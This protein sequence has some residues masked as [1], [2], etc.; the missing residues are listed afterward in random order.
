MMVSPTYFFEQRRYGFCVKKQS[1]PPQMSG[2]SV[3]CIQVLHTALK[4][5]SIVDILSGDTPSTLQFFHSKTLAQII[6]LHVE[7]PKGQK[8]IDS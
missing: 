1:T 6:C 5:C 2:W 7:H 4:W 8:A 3:Q